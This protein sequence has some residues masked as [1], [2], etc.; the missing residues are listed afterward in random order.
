MTDYNEYD[1]EDVAEFIRQ[2]NLIEGEDSVIASD[3]SSLAWKWIT[4]Q[5]HMGPDD[6]LAL[7][8]I[9]MGGLRPDIAG[10]LRSV[11]VRVGLWMA[12]NPGQVRRL[13][14]QWEMNHS[15]AAT[16]EAIKAAHIAFEKIHPFED[17]NGRVG[18][19]I[20][21]VQRERA[22]LPILIIH[23]GDEQKEYYKWF[24]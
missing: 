10:R 1:E 2:S 12:P 9:M 23:V 21:N 22:G 13:L 24:K 11:N 20:M 15:K 3:D 6:I 7:H 18:R 4:A 16:E 5:S 19:I 8:Q 14:Y 17:G